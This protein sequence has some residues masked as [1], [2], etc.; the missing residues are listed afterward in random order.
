MARPSSACENTSM[1]IDG[2]ALA[3]GVSAFASLACGNGTTPQTTSVTA[4]PGSAVAASDAASPGPVPCDRDVPDE[5]CAIAG[6]LRACKPDDPARVGEWRYALV[7]T[8]YEPRQDVTADRLAAMWRGDEAVTIAASPE[9]VGMVVHLLGPGKVG[10]L[11]EPPNID[12]SRWAIVPAHELTPHWRVVTIDGKHPLDPTPGP[13]A[14]PLCSA[15]KVSVRN[16]DPAKLTRIA[17]TGT[18]ALTRYTAKLMDEKGVLYPLTGVEPWLAGADL[19]HIS[20]EVSFHPKCDASGK[21]TM[22][23]C[24]RESYIELL[25]KSHAK[26]IELTGSHLTDYG[27]Q[28]LEHTIAMYEQR[29]WVWFGGGRTQLDATSPR[30]VE[31]NGNKLAFLGCNQVWTDNRVLSNGPGP[32]GCDLARMTWQIRDL[33]RRGY[34]PIVSVQHDEVYKHDP[35]HGLV[36]DLRRLAEAGP[37]FVMGS[38]AHCPHP[39]E[40]HRGAFVHYGPGNLY[41]DQFWHPVRDSAQDRLYIHAGKLLTVSQLYVRTE[42]RGRPRV[43]SDRE[44]AELLSDLAAA[45]RRLPRGAQPWAAPAEVPPSRERPDSIVVKGALVPVIVTEPAR[46]DEGTRHP[47]VIDLGGEVTG[48][49]D[50]AFVIALAPKQKRKPDVPQ[51]KLVATLTELLVGRYPVDAERI[52]VAAPAGKKRK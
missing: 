41:F 50:A 34:I 47:A 19:V 15:A 22:S 6:G 3:I 25:E 49:R 9:T 48:D 21:P 36:R 51:A 38:Q 5:A 24:S 17:M 32:G 20:N 30:I 26:I 4:A 44:R 10:V 29:G 7:A 11:A 40:V 28:W 35:P 8:L 42:E 23:F 13:L 16:I 46:L 45:Q 1:M 2:R 33:R 18:T 27:R 52:E 14:V 37:V 12:S 43:L 31:H 39:W